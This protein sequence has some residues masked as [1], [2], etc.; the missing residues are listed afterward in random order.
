MYQ[1]PPYF[2]Q[3]T[4]SA[5]W[6]AVCVLLQ[7]KMRS[8]K[9][10]VQLVMFIRDIRQPLDKSWQNPSMLLLGYS[11]KYLGCG[12]TRVE[13]FYMSIE[14]SPSLFNAHLRPWE[15]KKKG[16]YC[17]WLTMREVTCWK[18]WQKGSWRSL[19]ISNQINH[20]EP[21]SKVEKW[22][23]VSFIIEILGVVQF[24]MGNWTSSHYR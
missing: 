13:K 5:K 12:I 7:G 24:S 4:H 23:Q 6:L 22:N 10:C 11:L 16:K 17:T 20:F 15:S 8:I 14:C 2:A 1:W 3:K 18:L 21:N 9:A 19:L